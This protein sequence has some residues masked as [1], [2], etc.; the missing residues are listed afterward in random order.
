MEVI[1]TKT[2]FGLYARILHGC[3]DRTMTEALA[4]MD[5]TAAQGRIMG[6]LAR[7]KDPPC[8]R[9]IEEEFQLS[10]PTVS[11]LL[12]RLEKKGFLEFR[13]DPIDRR[14]KRIYIL[15][16]GTECT[17]TMHET[18]EKNEARMVRDFT[19]EEKAVFADLLRRAI[20]NMGGNPCCRKQKEE[21]EN[22]DY[23]TGPVYP[24]IQV[25]GFAQ[26]P[27]HDR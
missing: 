17:Q 25:G 23:T 5:L 4:E 24:G 19:E 22:N 9:D 13:P 18:I 16:K 8:S 2:R 12:T 7:R 1:P 6:Y 20:I 14:C 3:T 10:H 21:P 26:P 11:G 27:V 15:P